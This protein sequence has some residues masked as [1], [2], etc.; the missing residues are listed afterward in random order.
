[1][2]DLVKEP[3]RAKAIQEAVCTYRMTHG[4]GGSN[5]RKCPD[6]GAL[7]QKFRQVCPACA[8]RRRKVTFRD[9]QNRR[10]LTGRLP[11]ISACRKPRQG[12]CLPLRRVERQNGYEDSRCLQEGATS[13]DIGVCGVTLM[14]RGVVR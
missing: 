14:E 4:D 9:A 2:A 5:G 3:R 8:G 7:L 12:H 6:C 13:V 11:G 10:R 1:M